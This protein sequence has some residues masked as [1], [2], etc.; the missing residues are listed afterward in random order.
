MLL[1]PTAPTIYRLAEVEREPIAL[2]TNLGTYTNFVNPMDLAAIAVPSGFT[3]AGLPFG[4]TLIGRAFSEPLLAGIAAA[5]AR[6][7]SLPLGAM[8]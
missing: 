5:F 8:G 3:A 6:T 7:S 2:N 1:V 4:I